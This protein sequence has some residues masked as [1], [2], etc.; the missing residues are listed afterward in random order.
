MGQ[1]GKNLTNARAAKGPGRI[2]TASANLGRRRAACSYS[3]QVSQRRICTIM[4]T[5]PRLSNTSSS[6]NQVLMSIRL[7]DLEILSSR[8]FAIMKKSTHTSTR[9]EYAL[10]SLRNSL[11][12]LVMLVFFLFSHPSSQPGHLCFARFALR[13][14]LSLLLRAPY[15]PPSPPFFVSPIPS[16]FVFHK[17]FAICICLTLPPPISTDTQLESLSAICLASPYQACVSP[18]NIACFVFYRARAIF[19][20]SPLERNSYR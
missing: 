1:S 4:Q 12:V 2:Q 13:S 18:S 11:S 7:E 5:R 17:S 14:P 8:G 20:S 6:S 19:T 15:T 9:T 3:S 16:L 10:Y